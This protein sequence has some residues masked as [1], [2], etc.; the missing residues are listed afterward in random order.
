MEMEERYS[1]KTLSKFRTD[2]LN[3]FPADRQ[4]NG[5]RC[6]A[7]MEKIIKMNKYMATIITPFHN[8]D[9]RMFRSAFESVR[10]GTDEY[11]HRL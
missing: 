9:L 6:D 7:F 10:T 8:T 2:G 4:I 11:A 1:F 3:I 5:Q